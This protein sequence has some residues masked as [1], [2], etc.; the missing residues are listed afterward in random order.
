M[1]PSH[2]GLRFL[3][4]WWLL[5]LLGPILSGLV[6]WLVV[7]QMPRVYQADVTLLV[8][9]G[10]ATSLGAQDLQ[11]TQNL[12][13]TFAQAM[14]TRPVL[15][16]AATQVGL[17][18]LSAREL[19]QRV[20][21][22]GVTG[23]QLLRVSAEDTDPAQAAQLAN[24]VVQVFL[25]KNDDIQAQRF[26]SS[27]ENLVRLIDQ[28][29]HDIDARSQQINDLGAQ[30]PSPERDAQLVQRQ[31]DLTQLQVTHDN[32]VRSYEDLRVTE[33]RRVDALT[34]L[35]PAV[36]PDSPVQPNPVLSVLLAALAGAVAVVGIALV[37]EYIDD[38][39]RDRQRISA[40]TGLRTLGVIPRAPRA[41]ADGSVGGRL[42][43][44]YRLLRTN[45]RFAASSEARRCLLVASAAAGEG[46]ST[47]AANL[48]SAL[49]EAGQRVIL[50]DADLHQ[51]TQARRFELPSGPGLTSVL[52]D[53]E[54]AAATALH[55]TQV[56]NLQVVPAGLASAE[57]SAL[58]SSKRLPTVL[59]QLRTLCDVLL[60]D[61]PP[62]LAQPDAALLS[63]HADAVVF[64]IDASRSRQRPVRRALDMLQEAGAHVLGTVVNRVPRRTVEYTSIE[65]RYPVTLDAEGVAA[66]GHTGARS[67]T[68]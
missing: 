49:A 34:V 56:P 13:D 54:A 8:Q 21:A 12:A 18:N 25:T 17:G 53:P 65:A 44:S 57:P 19:S 66:N 10:D 27:R 67:G 4:R 40:S 50:L 52:L 41:S 46:K 14:L 31:A 16:E 5:L 20:Q 60:I 37:A 61:S 26:A 39:L 63:A 7:R 9:P 29:Q 28:L 62:L 6:G 11:G 38:G 33:A 23:T 55:A 48:A 51:P 22:R 3:R 35:D 45:L 43:E 15:T 68:P 42:A 47:I 32:T 36:P 24:A 1:T 59:G 30:P 64:V 58:L 2:P